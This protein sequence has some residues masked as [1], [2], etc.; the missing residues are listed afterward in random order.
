MEGSKLKITIAIFLALGIIP[1]AIV[2]PA[3][4]ETMNF[5][6]TI[7]PHLS[8]TVSNN[9]LAIN[10]L[11]PNNTGESSEIDINVKTNNTTGYTL[12]AT[13]GNETYNTTNLTNSATDNAFNSIATTDS[14]AKA[15]LPSSSWAYSIDSGATYSGLPLYTAEAKVLNDSDAPTNGDVTPL[16]I[17]ANA[18]VN[19]ASGDYENV[20]T[21]SLVPNYVPLSLSEAYSIAGK[22]R[23]MASD[24]NEY[25]SMQDMSP[26]ICNA[27]DK[28]ESTL[29]VADTRDGKVYWITKLKDGN[30]WMTQ[31][32]D[33]DLSV[34][35]NQ[36]LTP[37][38]SDVAE[39]R[40]VTP[41]A[42]NEDQDSIYY[43]DGGD[44]Y[45]ANGTTETSGYSNLPSNDINRHYAAG[46]YYSWKAATAGQGTASI[47]RTDVAESICPKGWRLPTSDSADVNYG[48][49]NLIKQ[50]GYT[51]YDQYSNTSDAALL[52]APLF[53]ARGGAIYSA[54][55]PSSQGD[56]G[57]Y[58]SSKAYSYTDAAHYL[59]FDNDS[60]APSTY[61]GRNA[62]YSV[63]CVA[64]G[65]TLTLSYDA[66]GGTNAPSATIAESNTTPIVATISYILPYKQGY[67]FLGYANTSDAITP[68]YVYADWAFTPSI[69]TL[70]AN[71]TIYAVWEAEN[72]TVTWNANGG[73]VSP[74]TTTKQYGTA[75]GTLPTPTY[76]GHNFGGWYTA[77]SGGT[78]ISATTTVT[79]DVTYYAHWTVADIAGLGYMQDMTPTACA[80]T[81]VGTQTQ[82]IDSRDNKL[83][84]VAKLKDGNCW[85][86]Q[87]LDYD[88]KATGNIISNN[89]GTTGT[90]SPNTATSTS[91]F[92]NS[93][94]TG[95]YSYDPGNYYLPSGSGSKTSISSLT[96][97]SIIDNTNA[98]HHLGNYYQWNAATAG[99]GGTI[100]NT[101][102]TSSICPK[103]WRLPTSNSD[104]ANYSFGNL[105]KQYG[106][107]GSNQSSTSDS[108]L[109]S[110]PLFFARGGYVY[111]G[112]L[113]DQGSVGYYWSSR[114]NSD[115]N[116]AYFL[117]FNS[118]YVGPSSDGYYRDGGFSVRCVAL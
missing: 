91:V 59:Y 1:A 20:I 84:W 53:F 41:V 106:Y 42:W 97:T 3:Q 46:D 78:Q 55:S 29:Q 25:Y 115:T 7:Q 108:T 65:N 99:T 105:V 117:Y 51:G 90:W 75:L 34:A 102:A 83:Y 95:T 107:T 19:M 18:A 96:D 4:A 32:L 11:L 103:G 58:W 77:A 93:S 110:S 23:I 52:A 70:T 68:D 54:G 71:K 88:I 43:I 36:A 98:H 63:R 45:Y 80:N 33:Y 74:T 73:S 47:T 116:R 2:A 26:E 104:S 28:V 15:D 113:Y 57:I 89:N 85:M 39:N 60:V 94:Y 30:C 114:A 21:F 50:Y 118:S 49:G 12:F 31:N 37:A 6:V 38:T 27:T 16:R 81:A 66:N 24:G 62:G 79:N 61:G 10:N 101:D 44:D 14:L 111:S 109:L 82:L 69:I 92:N 76:A 86:T 112:S 56:R 8:L 87:N 40:T 67:K 5:S 100:T 9:A 13:V 72:Y 64:H 22:T 35:V 17:A 48:F